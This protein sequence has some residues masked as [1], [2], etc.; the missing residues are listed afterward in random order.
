[1]DNSGNFVIDANDPVVI[2]HQESLVTNIILGLIAGLLVGLT[3]IFLLEY[4]DPKK[5]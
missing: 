5:K 3:T 2:D 1:M 4:L